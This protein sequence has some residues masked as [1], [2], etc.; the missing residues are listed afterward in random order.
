MPR[1]HKN[2]ALQRHAAWLQ[3]KVTR[4]WNLP[5]FQ[6]EYECGGKSPATNDLFRDAQRYPF[7][8]VE[9]VATQTRGD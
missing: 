4:G 7:P 1:N 5:C 6:Q 2:G 9:L 3:R 8:M